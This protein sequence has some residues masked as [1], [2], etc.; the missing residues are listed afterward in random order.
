M[1]EKRSS[2]IWQYFDD[3]G[4]HKKKCTLCRNTLSVKGGGLFNLT[5][6]MKT[7]HPT[8]AT[9][10]RETPGLPP[11]VES[12]EPVSISRPNDN[13]QAVAPD[14]EPIPS[15]SRPSHVQTASL[16]TKKTDNSV[17]SYLQRPM[18]SKTIEMIHSDLLELVA[19]NYLPFTIVESPSF[20]KFV[21]KLHPGY[22]IPSRKTLSKALL[23][24]Y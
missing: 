19:K 13:S 18:T 15:T 6:H 23:E 17:R 11:I 12:V 4:E 3:A 8:V 7:K 24:K 10:I 16:Q 9:T 21:N 20:R 5:R 2:P 22:P 14:P 1:V